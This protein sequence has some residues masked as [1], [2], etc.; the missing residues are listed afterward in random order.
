M[1]PEQRQPEIP[2]GLG[3][4]LDGRRYDYT[5]G[6]GQPMTAEDFSFFLRRLQ[7]RKAVGADEVYYEMLAAALENQRAIM[8]EG[9]NQLLAG[10]SI[11]EDWKGGTIRLLS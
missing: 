9:L 6:L 5:P 3:R 1:Q 8:L 4:L 2:E 11:P 10:R 7:H